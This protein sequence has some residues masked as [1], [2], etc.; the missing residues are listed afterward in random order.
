[1]TK[2]SFEIIWQDCTSRQVY[3]QWRALSDLGKL[4]SFW[5]NTGVLVHLADIVHPDVLDS[6]KI[7]ESLPGEAIEP[8]V[9]LIKLFYS[10]VFDF[11]AK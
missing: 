2:K 4:Y 6:L 7:E 9:S 1:L 3:D 8:G 10:S 5:Q 11:V